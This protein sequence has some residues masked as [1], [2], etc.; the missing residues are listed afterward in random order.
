M[1]LGKYLVLSVAVAGLLTPALAAEKNH[2]QFNLGS[3][4][5]I[6]SQTIKAGD[7]TAEWEG[8]GPSVQ[9]KILRGSKVVATSTANV[10][11]PAAPPKTDQVVLHVEDNG[12][13]TVQQIDFAGRKLSLVFEGSQTSS[14][15]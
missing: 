11:K 5:Q 12:S 14:G 6:S 7:Y 9:V 15:Q 3:P 10:V 13:R 1:T 4:A 2:A 8:T